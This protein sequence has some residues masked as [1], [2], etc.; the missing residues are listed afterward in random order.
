MPV[1]RQEGG[2]KVTLLGTVFIDNSTRTSSPMI[3]WTLDV[4]LPEI[5]QRESTVEIHGASLRVVDV[6]YHVEHGICD[7]VTVELRPWSCHEAQYAERNK[8]FENNG[9]RRR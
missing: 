9:W 7:K 6:V 1:L 3:H 8:W 2:V 4:R 5:P